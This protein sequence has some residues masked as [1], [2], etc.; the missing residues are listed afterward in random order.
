[1]GGIASRVLCALLAATATL[2]MTAIAGAHPHV[3]PMVRT[4]LIFSSDGRVTAIQHTW[5]YDAAYSTFA[6]R[7]IDANKDGTIAKDE[8]AAFAKSQI[9]AFIE[10]NYFTSV[11][12]Q[13]GNFEF[14]PPESYGAERLDDGRLELRF[15]IPFKTAPMA[16]NQLV[17]EIYDPNFFAYFTMAGD[18]VQLVGA[19]N[20]CAPMV[21]GPQPIDLRNTRSIPA[22][23]WQALKGSKTA[24]LQFINRITVE[25]P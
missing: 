22:V 3:L 10:H 23:F 17:V 12:T 21:V 15:T 6:A 11:T 8:L 16:D 1:M 13:A 9:G 25:C 4:G 20:G 7:D 5:T 24:G 14:G 18:A 19:P 2:M